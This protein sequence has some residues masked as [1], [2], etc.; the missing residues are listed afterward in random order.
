MKKCKICGNPAAVH[1]TQILNNEMQNV[2]LCEECAAKHGLFNH[3]GSPLSM[4]SVLG[5]AM[6]G[7]AQR[8]LA[9]V[10]SLICSRCGCT[11][12]GFKETG[13][14]GCENCYRDLKP[15]IDGIIEN[16]QKRTRHIG[17]RPGNFNE[18]ETSEAAISIT[19]TPKQVDIDHLK[20]ELERAIAEE[21]YEDA[22]R[23]R[24]EIKKRLG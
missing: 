7:S 5:E 11:P 4:L 1:L 10:N 3:G 13:R 23:L 18:A 14:L 20:L 17:K 22:A 12:A 15:L 2:D 24:D 19:V 21:R 16:S 8:D 9:A 6:F